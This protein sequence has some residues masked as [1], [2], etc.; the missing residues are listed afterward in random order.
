MIYMYMYY[1]KTHLL[2]S[3][4]HIQRPGGQGDSEQVYNRP[5]D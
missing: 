5:R 1:Y 4:T 2:S 3:N